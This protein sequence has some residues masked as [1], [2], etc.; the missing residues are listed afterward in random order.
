MKLKLTERVPI[1]DSRIEYQD[2]RTNAVHF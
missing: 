1:A 2:G